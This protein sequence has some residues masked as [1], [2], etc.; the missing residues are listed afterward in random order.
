MSD[1]RWTKEDIHIRIDE[2][3]IAETI[4]G[5]G[6]GSEALPESTP[7]KVVEAWNRLGG[8]AK[9]DV[10]AIRA[11]LDGDVSV[12]PLQGHDTAPILGKHRAP[13]T[14]KEDQL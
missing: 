11:W 3:G 10:A 6:I 5:Y 7:D 4:M 12:I 8:Q 13:I 9:A 1:G 2:S 14:G